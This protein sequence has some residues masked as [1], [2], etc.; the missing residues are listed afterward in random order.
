MSRLCTLLALPFAA[1]LAMAQTPCGQ[2]KLSLPDTTITSIELVAAGPFAAPAAAADPA[3]RNCR[4]PCPRLPV[5]RLAK[6][7]R[8][9]VQ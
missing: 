9:A 2:L 6:W 1:A 8:R 5:P 3:A 7:S 4:R